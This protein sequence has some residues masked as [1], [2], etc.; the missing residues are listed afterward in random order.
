MIRRPPRSTLF[1]Y[2]TLFR[3]R[4]AADDKKQCRP[5]NEQGEE[6]NHHENDDARC[7]F[8]SDKCEHAHSLRA[9]GA[10]DR[11]STRLNSSHSQI[12]YAVFCLK[13]KIKLPSAHYELVSSP[14][15]FAFFAVA[16]CIRYLPLVIL[17]LM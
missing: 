15:S 6:V 12:S 4:V 11:K 2:T 8:S 17:A 5:G 3:S 16:S 14:T 1:P 9:A 10:G 13:K 7:L